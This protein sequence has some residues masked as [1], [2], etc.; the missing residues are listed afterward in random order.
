MHARKEPV[1]SWYFDLKPDHELLGQGTPLS[2]HSADFADLRTARGAAARARRR[3]RSSLG[4]PPRRISRRSSP[5]SKP[6]ASSCSCRNPADRLVTVTAVNIPA[7]IDDGKVRRQLLDEFNIEI[8]GGLG[9]MKGKIWRIGLMGYSSQK[10]QRA[11]VSLRR[12]KRCCSIRDSAFRP[13]RA[14]AAAIHIYQQSAQPATAG[15]RKVAGPWPKPLRYPTIP[16]A[17]AMSEFI[18][19]F[20]VPSKVTDF[21]YHCRFS[22]CWNAIATRHSDTMDCKFLVDGKGR[23]PRPRAS[24]LCHLP[25]ARRTQ[26]DA[27]AKPATSPP[28]ISASVSNRKTSIRSTT[29]PPRTFCASSRNSPSTKP[30]PHSPN[31]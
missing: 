28:N 22:H 19:A 18:G 6:W 16:N 9:P 2:S 5:A 21:V 20:D 8:A 17:G 15:A 4:A 1:R 14:V 13:A 24:R 26:L 27:I 23:D 29:F 11:A 12:S 31:V 7:G 3:S 10:D 25:R 30:Y